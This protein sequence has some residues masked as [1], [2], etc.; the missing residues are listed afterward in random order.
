MVK[1]DKDQNV[2]MLFVYSFIQRKAFLSKYFPPVVNGVLKFIIKMCPC[3]QIKS[4]KYSSFKKYCEHKN[5]V[6]KLINCKR[7]C[8]C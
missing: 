8:H 2:K 3:I 1:T 4:Q 5:F 7:T 6:I